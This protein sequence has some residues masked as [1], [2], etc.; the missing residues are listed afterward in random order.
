M[1][2]SGKLSVVIPALQRQMQEGHKFKASLSYTGT[3]SNEEEKGKKCKNPIVLLMFNFTKTKAN[4]LLL[5][6]EDKIKKTLNLFCKR[7]L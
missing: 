5:I 7:L 1:E 6:S 2:R 3:L 4:Q